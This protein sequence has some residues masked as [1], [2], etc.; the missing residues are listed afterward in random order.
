MI[1]IIRYWNREQV[2]Q[3]DGEEIPN[4]GLEAN[5]NAIEAKGYR[6]ITVLEETLAGHLCCQVI[7][8]KDKPTECQKCKDEAAKSVA[9]GPSPYNLSDKRHPARRI[10]RRTLR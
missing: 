7:A 2:V 3:V 8:R 5:L 4:R 6:V 9:E 10:D 1:K